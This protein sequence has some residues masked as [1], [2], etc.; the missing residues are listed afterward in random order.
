MSGGIG[1]NERGNITNF[2]IRIG[3]RAGLIG[4]V[5]LDFGSPVMSRRQN[6]LTV[7]NWN[8]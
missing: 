2:S 6:T 4:V 1:E 3:N 8:H 5:T 7:E